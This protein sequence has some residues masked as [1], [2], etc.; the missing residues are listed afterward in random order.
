MTT[1]CPRL[2]LL[3]GPPVRP[4]GPPGWPT[5]D[6]AVEAAL[7]QALA[8]GSWGRYHGE[9]AGRLQRE[10]GT[11]FGCDVLLCGSGTFAVEVA[12][13]ALS[14]SPGDEVLLSAYD[15]PGNFLAIHAIGAQPVLVDVHP[16]NW[17]L[18]PASLPAEAGPRARAILVSHLHGGLVP[19]R[20]VMAWARERRLK[21]VE[22]A[23]Q[24]PGA[25]VQGRLA[26]T[27]GE[28][29][30]LSFGGSKL[31][32]AGRGGALL[33]RDEQVRQRAR[34]VLHR[35]NEVCPLSELQAAALLPQIARLPERHARRREMV[36]RLS[37][38]L[39]DIPG[40]RLFRNA[41]ED[42]DPAF[43]KVGFQLRE[44][45]QGVPRSRLVAALRAEGIAFDEGFPAL[46]VGRSPRRYRSLGPLDEATRAHQGVLVLHHPVLLGSD[47]D[48]RQVAEAISKVW[49]QA[50]ELR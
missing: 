33:I 30:I 47:D 34:L 38:W 13:R 7:A 21:V 2:A 50:H 31:L 20:E 37:Q 27:W 26:G 14:I 22:D 32:T 6:P 49:S 11:F 4:S 45:P 3:G 42:C 39:A 28:V 10:L 24:C 46:H 48:V 43:Y 23:A 9:W 44:A 5:A 8:D 25:V 36:A 40:L 12:L 29:G 35:G 19:M 41:A 15:Y 1:S 17:N 18:D 16:E